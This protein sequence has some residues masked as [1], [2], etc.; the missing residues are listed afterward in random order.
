MDEALPDVVAKDLYHGLDGLKS[1]RMEF[2][3]E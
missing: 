2:A 3:N 1:Q